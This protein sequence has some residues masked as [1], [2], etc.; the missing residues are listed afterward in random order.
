MKLDKNDYLNIIK[1]IINKGE[2][3]GTVE[4]EKG[5]EVLFVDYHLSLSGDFDSDGQWRCYN[6][7]VFIGEVVCNS[8]DEDN[9]EH[10]FDENKLPFEDSDFDNF[11]Y[12]H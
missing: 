7:T 6:F 1:E 11:G 4:Y 2:Y 5:D 12:L 9:L 3:E 10:D 8:H